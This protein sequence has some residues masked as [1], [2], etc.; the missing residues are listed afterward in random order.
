MGFIVKWIRR[1]SKSFS[2]IAEKRIENPSRS[3]RYD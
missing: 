3:Q 1:S 2:F